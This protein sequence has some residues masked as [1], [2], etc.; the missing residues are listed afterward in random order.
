[1]LFINRMLLTTLFAV[2]FLVCGVSGKS[3]VKVIFIFIPNKLLLSVFMITLILTVIQKHTTK[4]KRQLYS[5]NTVCPVI[6]LC[7]H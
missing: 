2:G 6:D 4:S 5:I 1:M 7:V 3:A